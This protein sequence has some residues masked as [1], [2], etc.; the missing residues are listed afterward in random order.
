[1]VS[2]ATSS[3]IGRAIPSSRV[4]KSTAIHSMLEEYIGDLAS[5][6]VDQSIN[7]KERVSQGEKVHLDAWALR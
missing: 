2:T 1:M 7:D 3:R 6:R 5:I 4:A